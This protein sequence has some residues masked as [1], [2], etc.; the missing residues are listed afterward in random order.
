MPV[1]DHLLLLST[2]LPPTYVTRID[3]TLWAADALGLLQ[4]VSC[5][6]AL[7]QLETHRSPTYLLLATS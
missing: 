6:S 3:A 1:E 5:T 7:V 4:V 2:Y